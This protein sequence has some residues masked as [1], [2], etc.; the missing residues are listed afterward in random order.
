MKWFLVVMAYIHA[1]GQGG[2]GVDVEV[3]E[4][5]TMEE[6]IAVG[7]ALHD[8]GG[9]SIRWKCTPFDPSLLNKDKL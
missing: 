7:R 8:I 9:K 1:G 3:K 5:K 2:V 4:L 6:C